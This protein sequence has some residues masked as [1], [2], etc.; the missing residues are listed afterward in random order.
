MAGKYRMKLPSISLPIRISLYALLAAI[1]FKGIAANPRVGR[2]PT[3]EEALGSTSGLSALQRAAFTPD[4]SFFEPIRNPESM[5][6]LA[7]HQEPGQTVSEYEK[8]LPQLKPKP[9]QTT[10]CLLPL[11]DFGASAPSLDT[12][13]DYCQAFF[14]M[15]TRVL[16]PVP[17]DQVPAKR[18]NNPNTKNLQLRTTDILTWLPTRKPAD[19]YALIAV[20]MTDLYPQDSWNFVFGQAMLQGGVGVFSFAR[21]DPAFYGEP[22]DAGT[23]TLILRRSCKVLSHE[24]GHMFGLYHCVFYECIMNGSNHLGETDSR[25]MHPCPVC[26]RKLQLSTRFDLL[27]RDRSLLEFFTTHALKSESDW[28]RR[29]IEKLSAAK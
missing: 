3:R 16:P 1:V 22:A 23:Q 8:V 7:Q 4:P 26:L 14:G 17:L 15:P 29:R 12:L 19:T 11:G 2:M 28:M 10:L 9:Q 27:Q 13:R 24:M 6:W 20:T 21:Y 18:R 5:D 25:P